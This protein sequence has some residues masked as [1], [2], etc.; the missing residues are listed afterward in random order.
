VNK[1]EIRD[2]SE[3]NHS[4]WLSCVHSVECIRN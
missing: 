3:L 4:I 2:R 1:R